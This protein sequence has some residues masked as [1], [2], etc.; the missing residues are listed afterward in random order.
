[1]CNMLA[2]LFSIE[3]CFAADHE[4]QTAGLE[5]LLSGRNSIAFI[6]DNGHAAGMI[7][8]QLVA[9]TAAGGYS[10]LIEDLFVM[11]EFREQGIASM[12]IAHL[13][14]WAKEAGAVRAQL[15]ADVMNAP[16]IA[17]YNKLGFGTGRMIGIYKMI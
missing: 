6:A 14:S 2:G 16:A 9:S 12:L 4:K 15:V 13:I 11:P 5:L 3:T 17:L 8:G 10:V 1:M 7:T